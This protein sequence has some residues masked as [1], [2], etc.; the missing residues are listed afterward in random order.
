MTKINTSGEI[1]ELAVFIEG[2]AEYEVYVSGVTSLIN[3]KQITI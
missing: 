2:L 1:Y 3:Q